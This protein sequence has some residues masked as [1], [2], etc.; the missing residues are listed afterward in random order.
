MAYPIGHRV[1][2]TVKDHNRRPPRRRVVDRCDEVRVGLLVPCCRKHRIVREPPL[3][4]EPRIDDGVLRYVDA[5]ERLGRLRCRERRVFDV[6][7]RD[8]RAGGRVDEFVFETTYG[9]VHLAMI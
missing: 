5:D 9:W 8:G 1:R 3:A 4:A 7:T 6:A 2:T